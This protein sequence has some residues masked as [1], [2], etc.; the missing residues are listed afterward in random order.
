MSDEQASLYDLAMFLV[1]NLAD[2]A[3]SVR[4]A[5]KQRHGFTTFE[6][7][8]ADED[9]GKV[10]GRQGRVA[11]ALRQVMKAAGLKAGCKVSLE[12]LS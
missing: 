12:I 7:D 5:P 3:D 1:T 10:I 9:L 4:I 2:H 6:V 8:V 11:N